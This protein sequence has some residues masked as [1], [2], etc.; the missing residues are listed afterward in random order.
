MIGPQRGSC[1]HPQKR[2]ICFLTGQEGRTSADVIRILR[3][4]GYLRS[5]GCVHSYHKRPSKGK[6]GG[7]SE[8]E[9]DVTAEAEASVMRSQEPRKAGSPPEGVKGEPF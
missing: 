2:K 1:P 4:G 9:K 5:F 8:S 6:E 3:W 7:E